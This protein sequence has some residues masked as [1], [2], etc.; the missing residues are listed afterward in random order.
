[1]GIHGHRVATDDTPFFMTHSRVAPVQTTAFPSVIIHDAPVPL[2]TI[3][4]SRYASRAGALNSII[5]MINMAD[6]YPTHN[7]SRTLPD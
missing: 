3:F 1:M 7:T 5:T 2:N 6:K 4:W